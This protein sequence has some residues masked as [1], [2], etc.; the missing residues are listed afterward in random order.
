MDIN[1]TIQRYVCHL[2]VSYGEISYGHILQAFM[3]SPLLIV[4][5][6]A[7]FKS[8][9]HLSPTKMNKYSMLPFFSLPTYLTHIFLSYW[10]YNL[11]PCYLRPFFLCNV[12]FNQSQHGV[13]VGWLKCTIDL[14]IQ[15]F[16]LVGINMKERVNELETKLIWTKHIC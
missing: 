11:C 12:S 2:F 13:I 16:Q 8:C 10:C 6:E 15:L 7:F 1:H 5:I 3:R 9:K 4:T 14:P